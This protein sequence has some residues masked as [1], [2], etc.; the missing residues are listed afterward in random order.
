MNGTFMF[1][2][3]RF[4]DT[5][6]FSAHYFKLGGTFPQSEINRIIR[7]AYD[8]LNARYPDENYRH[9]FPSL[10][11]AV[12]EFTDENPDENEIA[13]IVETFAFH[14]L[15]HIPP[16]YVAALRKLRKCFTLAA[17]IDIW[18]PK[19]AWLDAF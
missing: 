13:K 19:R 16:D 8:Y 6:D 5:E 1:G 3:D 2:E 12:R 18:S 17:V 11:S 10:E 14:E 4:G 7:A 9:N 15:G